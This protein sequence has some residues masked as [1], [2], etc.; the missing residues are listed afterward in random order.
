MAQSER[1]L[2]SV[3][4]R[5]AREQARRREQD[6]QKVINANRKNIKDFIETEFSHFKKNTPD[7]LLALYQR[8]GL[9]DQS[10]AFQRSLFTHVKQS[11]VNER[12]FFI[13]NTSLS[14]KPLPELGDR[15]PLTET[16]KRAAFAAGLDDAK[17][18]FLEALS[19]D[20]VPLLSYRRNVMQVITGSEAAKH[21]KL[22][23]R[24]E[25]KLEKVYYECVYPPFADEPIRAIVIH[26]ITISRS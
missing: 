22:I 24:L 17:T 26:P 25:T 18:L 23:G 11:V 21:E 14:R 10:E 6:A 16:A 12:R 1:H 9:R 7:G 8:T 5:S 19:R 2:P 13:D 3:D 20:D 4:F 15:F